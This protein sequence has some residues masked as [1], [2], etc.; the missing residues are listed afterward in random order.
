[1]PGFERADSLE[2]LRAQLQRTPS[3]AEQPHVDCSQAPAAAAACGNRGRGVDRCRRRVPTAATTAHAWLKSIASTRMRKASSTGA[4]RISE[5]DGARSRSASAPEQ[6]RRSSIWRGAQG[7]RGWRSRPSPRCGRA[8]SRARRAAARARVRSCSSSV[9]AG[10]VRQGARPA[11]IVAADSAN[12]RL[13]GGGVRRWASA[14]WSVRDATWLRGRG[15]PA[16]RRSL[17]LFGRRCRELRTAGGDRGRRRPL[18]HALLAVGRPVDRGCAH[19]R[20]VAPESVMPGGY[21]APAA[22]TAGPRLLYAAAQM[23]ETVTVAGCEN[24][25][26]NDTAQPV[27]SRSALRKSGSRRGRSSSPLRS[28]ADRR[29]SSP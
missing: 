4:C 27:S 21:R 29:R 5:P 7:R 13:A 1:M 12:L 24:P 17:G 14:A 10:D 18:S 15:R 23:A 19:R 2:A 25:V 11:L 26:A 16:P 28:P 9:T 20:G 6:S 22:T 3:L 8:S